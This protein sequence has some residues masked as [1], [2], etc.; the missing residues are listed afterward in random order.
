[1]IIQPDV[2]RCGGITEIRKIAELGGVY[3]A[4]VAHYMWYGL[5]T[6]MASVLSMV[7][8]PSAFTT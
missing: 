2:I 6:Q 4:E 5:V 3:R 7:A 1:M 8:T